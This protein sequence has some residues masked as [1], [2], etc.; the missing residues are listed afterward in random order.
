MHPRLDINLVLSDMIQLTKLVCFLYRYEEEK[1]GPFGDQNDKNQSPAGQ[2]YGSTS[3]KLELLPKSHFGQRTLRNHSAS[4]GSSGRT[5]SSGSSGDYKINFEDQPRDTQS[6][7][8]SKFIDVNSM[9]TGVQAQPS[10]DAIQAGHSTL[11]RMLGQPASSS[12]MTK[13]ERQNAIKKHN[14]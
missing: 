10:R 5:S 2:E 11:G 7:S 8:A 9:R 12:T 14:R 13:Q 6:Y 3:S 1:R 4:A